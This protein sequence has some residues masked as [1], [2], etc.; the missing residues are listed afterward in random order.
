MPGDAEPQPGQTASSAGWVFALLAEY[1]S[2]IPRAGLEKSGLVR[3]AVRR[4]N[5]GPLG[6]LAHL[7]S[8]L[9]SSSPGKDTVLQ[10][11]VDGAEEWNQRLSSGL[12]MS[13]QVP[14]HEHA[15]VHT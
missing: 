10:N 15:Y 8:L 14:T 12:H 6:S 4:G 9:L 2:W 1:Q 3:I 13:I 11:K 7:P 5:S